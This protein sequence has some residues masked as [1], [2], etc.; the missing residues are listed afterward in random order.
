[1]AYKII[2][3]KKELIKNLI[4]KIKLFN[5]VFTLNEFNIFYMVNLIPVLSNV[6]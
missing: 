6:H 5:N 3:N 1:M 4:L 2:L